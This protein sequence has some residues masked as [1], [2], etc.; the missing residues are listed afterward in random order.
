[1]YGLCMDRAALADIETFRLIRPEQA[2]RWLFASPH[3]G[4]IYPDDMGEDPRLAEAALRSAEDALVDQ[5]IAPGTEHGA[6]LLLGRVARAYVDLNRQAEDLDPDLVEGVAGSASARAA[7]GY[8]VIPRLNGQGRPL[9]ARQLGRDEAEAR[10]A[11]VHQPY[12]A[13]LETELAAIHAREGQVTL[14]DWHS[15]PARAT[16][17]PNGG[18]GVDVVLGDRH[19]S[20]CAA[21]LTRKARALFEAE[22]MKVALNHPYAGG[23]T[24]ERWGHPGEGF[25]A[26]Q[27]ELSRALYY[28]EAAQKPGPGW[29]RT[30]RAISR[31]I[32]GLTA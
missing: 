23:W 32:A 24:T 8:G 13:A 3:A 15:M 9:Y 1:M 22:G 17:G 12:H 10:L 31:I 29:A 5:L 7:A 2:G 14:I 26:L 19:G 20:S 28:D 21:G 6:T 11:A 4:T 18:R 27:I 25:H 30:T 16:R